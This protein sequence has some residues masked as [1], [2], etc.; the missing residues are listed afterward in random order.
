M[1]LVLLEVIGKEL[2][3]PESLYSRSVANLFSNVEGMAKNQLFL[4]GNKD[5]R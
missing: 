2:E 4:A 5:Q 3:I 1:A